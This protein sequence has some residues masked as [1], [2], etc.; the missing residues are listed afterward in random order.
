MENQELVLQE[1]NKPQRTQMF[2]C[3]V[4]KHSKNPIFKNTLQTLIKSQGMRELDFYKKLRISRQAWYQLSWKIWE[5][6]EWLKIKISKEL[7]VDSR[8]IWPAP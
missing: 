8:V 6:S 5:P 3:R 4:V 1:P 2:A 7:G